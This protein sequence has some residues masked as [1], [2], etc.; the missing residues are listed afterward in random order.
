LEVRKVID[1]PKSTMADLSRSSSIDYA[2]TATVQK[3]V[4]S[5]FYAMP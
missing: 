3:L 2:L 5:S 4:N 1:N